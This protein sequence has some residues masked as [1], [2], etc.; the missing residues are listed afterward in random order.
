MNI[1]CD[2]RALAGPLTGVGVWTARVMGDLAA[3]Y[4]VGVLIAASRPLELPPEL[5]H[6]GVTL[7]PP[8]RLRVPGTLWLHSALPARLAASGVDA[9]VG[10]L[11][12][13][14]RR[15][16]VPA[17]AVVHDLTPR[18]HPDRHTLANRFCFNAY[19]EESLGRAAAVV[20]VSRAT[21]EA[22]LEH[23]PRIRHRLRCIPNGVDDF[24]SPADPADDGEGTRRRFSDGRPYIVHLGTLEPR[25]GIPTLVEA[26]ERLVEE[27]PDAPDL[28][29]AGG[30]GWGTAPILRRVS[31]SP[32]RSRIHLP[33]YVQRDAARDLLRHAELFVLASEAEGF[34]MPLAEALSCGT[35]AVA[36]DI[37]ALR[38][39]AGGAA[40]LTPPGQTA[41][42]AAALASALE[43][44]TAEALRRRALERAVELRW[45][46]RVRQWYELLE[47]VVSRG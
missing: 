45:E 26:W 5:E 21:S 8:P 27:H 12:V 15:C 33:G 44:A 19:V 40:L 35:P 4:G 13:V 17:V 38:E 16:P 43:P 42:L 20:T 6:P 2:G 10:S 9:F 37:P 24:F 46:P 7:L 30:P 11:A 36:S 32:L 41:P 1:A 28:V 18:T 14:P 25:K 22:V 39:V 23:F 34:G 29:L 47:E 3:R 31:R